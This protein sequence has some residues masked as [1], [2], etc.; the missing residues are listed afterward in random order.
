MDT[1][2]KKI[3]TRHEIDRAMTE[4]FEQMLDH[5]TREHHDK[6]QYNFKK[7]EG[8]VQAVFFFNERSSLRISSPEPETTSYAPIPIQSFTS[9]Y[10]ERENK[11]D[12]HSR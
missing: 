4:K 5:Q 3:Q 8:K 10:S 1:H 11:S 12:V 9:S 6:T 2:S 7:E